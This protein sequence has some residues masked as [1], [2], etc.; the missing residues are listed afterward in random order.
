MFFFIKKYRRLLFLM[1]LPVFVQSAVTI[2]IQFLKGEILN[3]AIQKNTNALFSSIVLFAIFTLCAMGFQQIY[4]ALR[5]RFT[6]KIIRDIKNKIFESCLNKSLFQVPNIDHAAVLARY[7]GDLN[8]VE[9]NFFF[10]GSR[11][12]EFAVTIL[13]A[14]T[15]LLILNYRI[16]LLTIA[17]FIIPLFITNAMKD[18]ITR[19]QT[20]YVDTNK[21]HLE[22]LMK[23][24]GGLEAVKNYGIER[25]IDAIYTSSLNRLTESDIRRSFKRSLA[26]GMSFFSTMISQTATLIYATVL[27][28]QG[29]IDAGIFVTI[30]S[31]IMVLRPPFY[32]ISQLYEAVIASRPAMAK[33]SDLIS[34]DNILFSTPLLGGG[35]HSP[36]TVATGE[37]RIENISF[38]YPRSQGEPSTDAV[39]QYVHAQTGTHVQTAAPNPQNDDMIF[40][41]FSLNIKPREK[42]LITGG[43]GSGKSTLIKL[44]TGMLLPQKGRIQMGGTFR[45]FTQ[46]AFL[47]AGSVKENLTL[48]D[49]TVPEEKIEAAAKICG[50]SDLLR[51][52]RT[53][54]EQGANLSGGEKK[55]VALARTLLWDKDI[56]ILDEPLANIDPENIANIERA[57]LEDR[58]HTVL[59]ISHICSDNLKQ[60]A[61]QIIEITANNHKNMQK[62]ARTEDRKKRE[63]RG[64]KTEEAV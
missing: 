3:T 45:Y 59:I 12:F 23:Y 35:E 41:N 5:V 64:K 18:G 62:T 29:E 55:R 52:E 1:L 25:E 37:I 33:I 61:D 4:I 31:L 44:L 13:T 8:M 20:D 26:N 11:L 17:V 58:E 40:C 6:A 42:V 53:V 32:W 7:T 21:K 14:G 10:M 22:K 54:T 63:Y 60:K 51:D 46:D 2:Q 56:L 57:I 48:F 43:S 9:T 19:S 39:H 30:F 34:S 15:T 16:G 47:F 28:Y 24:L 49:D 27:L 36:E 50:I 38:S